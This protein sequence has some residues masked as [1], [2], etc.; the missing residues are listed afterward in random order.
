ML[1]SI[2]L[3]QGCAAAA[4]T[5]GGIAAGVGVNHTLS[6]ITYKTVIAPLPNTRLAALKAL[7]RMEVDI[8]KDEETEDGWLI[9]GDAAD[10]DIDIQLE[11]LT[12]TTTR[13]RVTVNKDNSL[14]KDRAT[15]TEIIAQSVQRLEQDEKRTAQN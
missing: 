3:L 9:T 1:G 2:L 11:R 12:P 8:K 7:N 4:L 13:M 15:A 5:A 14:L 10:R 6:G